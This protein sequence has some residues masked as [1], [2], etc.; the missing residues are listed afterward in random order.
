[1][2]EHKKGKWLRDGRTVYALNDD[3]VP[4][5]VFYTSVQPG[6]RD[7]KRI[8]LTECEEI[9]RLIAAAPALLELLEAA[10]AGVEAAE[11]EEIEQYRDWYKHAKAA[12]AEATGAKDNS[13]DSGTD[14]R[15][16]ALAK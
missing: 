12:I 13:A 3:F 15:N 11:A 14:T 1:M 4:S 5:N 16:G 8:S 2:S 6:F 9:A 10:V 7:G